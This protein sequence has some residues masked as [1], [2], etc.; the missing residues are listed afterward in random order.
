MIASELFAGRF[1]S[2]LEWRGAEEALEACARDF[3]RTFM[4]DVLLI[5]V[6]K[7]VLFVGESVGFEIDGEDV[8]RCRIDV[9]K[10]SRFFAL[11][12]GSGEIKG[13]GVAFLFSVTDLVS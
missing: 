11:M 6:E 10:N 1:C 12:Y 5:V 7:V 8:L 9:W 13:V 4:V 2:P 3:R